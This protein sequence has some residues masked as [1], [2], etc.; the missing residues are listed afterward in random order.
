MLLTGAG[1]LLKSFVRL[2]NVNPGFNPRNV[3]TAEISSPRLR[4]PDK[5]AQTNFF[6]E[7]E[8]RVASLP[9]VS[10]CQA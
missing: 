4:Y 5:A 2:Q 8:R 10:S 3:L 6:A 7:L 9:G 1:L